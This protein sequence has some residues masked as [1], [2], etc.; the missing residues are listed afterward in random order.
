MFRAN[1][2]Y[3]PTHGIGATTLHPL[4]TRQF[5]GMQNVDPGEKQQ[6]ALPVSMCH[7]LHRMAKSNLSEISHM[8]STIAWL[9][10]LAYFWRMHSCEYS[11]VQ[12]ELRT[13]IICV[14]NIWFFDAENWD[15]SI[16]TDLFAET[17]TVSFTFEFQKK[18]VCNNRISHQRS[19]D[20]L[21]GGEMCPVR[22]AAK[23]I[24][25]IYRYTLPEVKV[26]ETQLNYVEIAGKGFTIPSSL[27]L[28]R[29]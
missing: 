3:N 12:G 22:A 20:T 25:Q 10:T 23:I 2:G 16:F 21:E 14:K 15:I 6:K 28:S 29:I 13:K 11:D 5:W 18:D 8:D 17:V 1:I 7:K 26:M 27:I 24:K 9:Q 4:L 19:G